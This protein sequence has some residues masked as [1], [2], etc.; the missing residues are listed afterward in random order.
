MK[1][2]TKDVSDRLT[3]RERALLEQE[4]R[5]N[6][7]IDA[8]LAK[9]PSKYPPA[10][11]FIIPNEMCERFCF[12]GIKN[13]LNQYMKSAFGMEEHMAKAQSHMFNGLVYLFPLVG[14]AVSD[15][16]LGKYH[17]IVCFSVVYLIGNALLSLFSINGLLG[18]FGHYPFW[19]YLIPALLIAVGTGGIKP[20]VS[21]HGG[22]QFL[23][24]QAPLVDKFFSL[25]YLS[26]NVGALVAQY[27]TP[28]LKNYVECFGS[29]CYLLAFGLPTLSFALA[30]CLFIAGYRYYRIVPAQGEF[31]PWKAAKLTCLAC[32]R[33]L[34]ASKLQR[35]K[36]GH[37]LSFAEKEYGAEFVEETRLLGKVIVMSMPI[38]FFSMLYDQSGTEWQNQYEKMDKMLLGFIPIPTEASS[39]INSVFILILVPFLVYCV[40][41]F[42]ERRG[43][44][45]PVITRMAWGFFFLIMA[46]V[47]ST[48]LDYYV[49]RYTENIVYK[50]NVVVSCEGCLNGTWQLPQWFLLSLGEAMLSPTA[51]QFAYTQV[52]RQMKAS[53]SSLLLLTTSLGNYVVLILEFP[54]QGIASSANRQWVYVT[55]ATFFFIVFILLSKFWFVS[56]EE[57]IDAKSLASSRDTDIQ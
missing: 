11:F 28:Y 10:I 21:A 33:W 53:S 34:N 31:L 8:K 32:R 7:E 39:N 1:S 37:W 27:L 24:S 46:F 5:I 26:I 40:Y 29:E 18:S 38:I 55:I 50:D 2:P 9:D 56:K 25:F 20:C 15:S 12:Y 4:R 22:D 41:P 43:I 45:M 35:E 49:D 23:P 36:V 48:S 3:E 52:G 51:N 16:F 30:L 6:E 47:V 42:L 57:E 14:A 54:L 17:T 13:L 19:G 44:R